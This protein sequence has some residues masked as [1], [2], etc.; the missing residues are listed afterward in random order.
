MKRLVQIAI[1]LGALASACHAEP[2]WCSISEVDPSNKFSY[3][4]IAR[5]ARVW[6]TVTMR[7]LYEPNGKVVRIEPI[8]GPRLLSESLRGQLNDW[9]V[10]TDAAGS[11]LCQTLV[12]AEF[13]LSDASD[14]SLSEPKIVLEPS[15]LRLS[16]TVQPL[17][18]DVVISDPA[19]LKGWKLVRF[20]IR[21]KLR[22][23][24]GKLF[25]TS[26]SPSAG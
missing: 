15:I 4:P 17:L 26:H 6:G 7:M 12:I 13:Y 2:R 14:S 21:S 23:V 9:I 20:E 5:V 19:P 1:C 25:G 18:L 24:F 3:P 10:K 11:E 22:H 8:S 16:A